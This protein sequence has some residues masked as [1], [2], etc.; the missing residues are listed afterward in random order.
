LEEYVEETECV[1]MFL[2]KG[3][4]LSTNVLREVDATISQRKPLVKVHEGDVGRGGAPLEVLLA[5]I[6][7]KER[8]EAAQV[9]F[10]DS[11]GVIIRWHRVH[12]FQLL[13]LKMIAEQ[14]LSKLPGLDWVAGKSNKLFMPGELSRK[15]LTLGS[16]VNLY[17]SDANPGAAEFGEELRCRF[18]E[19]ANS[20]A[21][22]SQR[23]SVTNK[24]MSDRGSTAAPGESTTQ[25]AGS[26]TGPRRIGRIYRRVARIKARFAS[27]SSAPSA[28]SSGVRLTTSGEAAPSSGVSLH[29]DHDAP[30]APAPPAARGSSA[31]RNGTANFFITRVSPEVE[32][33]TT[34]ATSRGRSR[35]PGSP[36]SPGSPRPPRLALR[37][38][39]KR[40]SATHML[41]YLNEATFVAEGRTQLARELSWAR[42]HNMPIL[43]VHENDPQRGGCTF[44]RFFQ[45]TPQELI[46]AGLYRRI[47]VALQPGPHRQISLAMAAKELGAHDVQRRSLS[48]RLAASQRRTLV[49][50]TTKLGSLAGRL[51]VRPTTTK[52]GS[53]AGRLS[54]RPK[55]TAPTPP[56]V[57]FTSAS[58]ID[59]DGGIAG[60]GESEGARTINM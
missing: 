39:S 54:V 59:A 28:V 22:A 52:L 40:D 7:A 16:R 37:S 43:M 31:V 41:L 17:I 36:G 51:S 21:S 27:D 23:S 9:I 24:N 33:S 1:L 6:K 46:E 38:R 3:Y 30:P 47:A 58:D 20:R 26:S 32:R 53:L 10:D 35:S 5:D 57:Q 50:T 8:H 14:L 48:G 15:A 12:D 34:R 60:L 29:V 11:S 55:V 25:A 4:F 13:S 19:T 44:D 18:A 42:R 49:S 45:T 56:Q 2:S